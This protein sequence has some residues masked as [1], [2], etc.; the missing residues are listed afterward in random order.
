MYLKN[1]RIVASIDGLTMRSFKLGDYG[2]M[3]DPTA[4]TGWTDGVSV[5]R[6]T[7]D[8][9]TSNGNF[10]DKA[11]LAA[12]AVRFSGV[13]VA[14]DPEQL[15][16]M[17]DLFT[18]VLAHGGFSELSVE[19][20]ASTRYA[21]VGLEGTP[22]WVV[23]LDNVALW[24]IEFYAPDPTIYSE[25]RSITIGAKTGLGG[26]VYP[27]QYPL[28]YS[29]GSPTED[30]ASITN[31]GNVPSW[32]IFKVT[33]DYF[34]GVSIRDN[35]GNVVTYTGTITTS[36]PIIV[37]MGAGT[38]IQSGVD[39]STLLSDRQW[40]SV[41]PNSTIRPEYIPIQSGTGWCDI[42]IRDTWI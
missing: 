34:S 23:Q 16:E 19:T 42:I 35:R 10:S 26:L 17:R 12:R 36:A 1:D 9:P 29:T 40:F 41:P 27:L 3:L 25:A 18:S 4:L 6:T 5:R 24:K 38:V 21:T 8:R 11:T 28:V 32:P 2:F 33:G 14:R 30:A 37:D 20:L 15:Q 31:F 22:E 39:K 7:T 13:A